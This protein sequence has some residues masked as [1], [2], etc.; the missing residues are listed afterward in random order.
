MSE[1]ATRSRE[2]DEELQRSTKKVKENHSLGSPQTDP[3][4]PPSPHRMGICPTKKSYLEKSLGPSS[5]L[6]TSDLTWT[7]KWNQMMS[8]MSRHS[9]RR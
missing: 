3:P 2:E 6:L 5:K 7:P 4:P 1:T 9:A 8:S